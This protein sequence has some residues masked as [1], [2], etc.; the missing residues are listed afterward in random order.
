MT[1]EENVV[2]FDESSVIKDT[3]E[4]SAYG[5]MSYASC[6]QPYVNCILKHKVCKNIIYNFNKYTGICDPGSAALIKVFAVSS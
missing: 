6:S 1:Q 3:T 5:S 2:C 4:E